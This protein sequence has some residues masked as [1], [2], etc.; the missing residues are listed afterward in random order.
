MKIQL[1]QSFWLSERLHEMIE[2]Q[3][4][5]FRYGQGAF[6]FEDF[7]FTIRRGEAWTVIGPSGC[8]KTTL[9]YLIAGLNKPGGGEIRIGGGKNYPCPTIY[10]IGTPGPW[11]AALGDD[12]GKHQAGAEGEKV[13]W[14]GWKTQPRRCKT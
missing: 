7:T 13:L 6:L 4:L 11:A 5:K 2:V 8:G 10:W 3:N 9:L 1:P 12:T 14:A